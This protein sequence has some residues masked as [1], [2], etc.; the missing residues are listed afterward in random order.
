MEEIQ[1]WIGS[2]TLGFI[3]IAVV[4]FIWMWCNHRILQAS[5]PAVQDTTQAVAGAP[6]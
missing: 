3:L 1:A 4:L 5:A 6:A 2:S